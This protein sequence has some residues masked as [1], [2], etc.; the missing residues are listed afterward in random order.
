MT[1]FRTW[2]KDEEG[3]GTLEIV[4]IAAVVI[5]IVILFRGWI[6]DF[7]QSLF[8]KVENKSDAFFN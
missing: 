8:D 1:G 2:M 7:L 6:L 4:L 5:A 3:I